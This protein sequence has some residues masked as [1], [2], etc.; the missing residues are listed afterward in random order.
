[1]L[2]E[3]YSLRRM[4]NTIGLVHSLK[5][6]ECLKRYNFNE[7][8]LLPNYKNTKKLVKETFNSFF[9]L[10]EEEETQEKIAVSSVYCQI[11]WTV[12]GLGFNVLEIPPKKWQAKLN[13]KVLNTFLNN[14]IKLFEATLKR[15]EYLKKFYHS[16]LTMKATN[17]EFKRAFSCSE[18]FV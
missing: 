3:W 12:G 4:T 16:L 18:K 5:N 6:S 7:P 9:S 17:I 1:M 10:D 2:R 15:S 14:K 8:F 13:V 11:R